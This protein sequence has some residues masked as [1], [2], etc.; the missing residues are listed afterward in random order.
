MSINGVKSNS[1]TFQNLVS[2]VAQP[3]LLGLAICLL[4][5]VFPA[6]KD[7]SSLRRRPN[8]FYIQAIFVNQEA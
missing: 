7:I 8:L 5:S 3:T 6:L 2:F 4:L 1:Y